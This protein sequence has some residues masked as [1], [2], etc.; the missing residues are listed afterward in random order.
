M[1]G[2]VAVDHDALVGQCQWQQGHQ[3]VRG[4]SL[5]MLLMTPTDSAEGA[6]HA[7]KED[8]GW[9]KPYLEQQFAP[10]GVGVV[11][12]GDNATVMDGRDREEEDTAIIVAEANN[13]MTG[14][15]SLSPLLSISIPLTML[16]LL[17]SPM[18]PLVRPFKLGMGEGLMR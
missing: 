13:A 16:L 8:W 10:T 7:S 17:Y 6:M 18:A 3:E 11:I 14:P 12:V 2:A 9:N 15:P 4:R 1:T 5:A